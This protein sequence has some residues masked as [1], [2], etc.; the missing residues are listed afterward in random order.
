MIAHSAVHGPMLDLVMATIV[1]N[2][3][4]LVIVLILRLQ[5]SSSYLLR[6]RS[7]RA[8]VAVRASVQW[9]TLRWVDRQDSALPLSSDEGRRKGLTMK[10][11]RMTTAQ[12]IVR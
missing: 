10:T 8:T 4:P 7:W 9:L 2:V 12:A 5:V 1:W 11:M 3:H 6:G